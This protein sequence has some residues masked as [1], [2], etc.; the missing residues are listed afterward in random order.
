MLMDV[1]NM[2]DGG[3]TW[4]DNH[5]NE[6]DAHT[7]YEEFDTSSF[8]DF[9]DNEDYVLM[10]FAGVTDSNGK[11]IYEGDILKVYRVM[12]PSNPQLNEFTLH[13]VKWFGETG[14]PAFDLEPDFSYDTINSLQIA[15]MER[16]GFIHCEVIGNIFQT[17]FLL[18]DNKL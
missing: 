16:K 11:D 3:G 2:Y 18:R 4:F 12:H 10:E 9:I 7:L 8:S 14:Y 17:P 13:Q 6:I 5:G 1:Q 15:V